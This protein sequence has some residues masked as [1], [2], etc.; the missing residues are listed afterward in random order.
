[1]R[2]WTFLFLVFLGAGCSCANHPFVALPNG[3]RV[4]VQIADDQSA[5]VLGLSGIESLEQD[6]GLLFLHET[7][8]TQ[9]YWMKDMLIP[10]DL[11][12][13]D[14]NKVAGFV[15]N[16]QPEKPPLTIYSSPVPVD[17]V[18]EVSSGFV[19]KNGLE[20]G[21]ILDIELVDE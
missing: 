11:I 19:A 7:T 9:R 8:D 1:M 14:G 20:I 18:L 17:K 16:A 4:Q 21:D 5:R 12:W 3:T 13:I 2:R 10:I 15:E 6:Q